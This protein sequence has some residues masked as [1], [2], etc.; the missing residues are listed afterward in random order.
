LPGKYVLTVPLLVLIHVLSGISTAGV[1]L[2]AAGLALKSAP[3]GKATA[4]LAVN[5]IISGT[6]ATIAPI[7]AGIASDH[8]AEEHLSIDL[9]WLS[10]AIERAHV[11]AIDLQG[12]DFI[13]VIAF[14]FGL[15]ALHRLLAV[16]EIGEVEEDVVMG[17]LYGEFAQLVRRVSNV[18]GGAVKGVTGAM[19]TT[20]RSGARQRPGPLQP[21][22]TQELPNASNPV[23]R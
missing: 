4:F 20:L 21:E 5:A 12:L 16:R 15:Y 7:L 18:P 23:K 9:H 13:F 22:I 14:V 11:T 2:S 19:M 3:K 8:F 1:N 17:E 6:A 10:G